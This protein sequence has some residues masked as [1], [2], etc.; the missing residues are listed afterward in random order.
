MSLALSASRI[1]CVRMTRDAPQ[2]RAEEV[3]G[4]RVKGH[5]QAREW[6]QEELASKM[7][8]AGFPWTQSIVTRTETATRPVRVD[9]AAALAALFGVGVDE[10]IGTGAKPLDQTYERL[11]R[12]RPPLIRRL[13]AA[14]RDREVTARELG[15]LDAKLAAV[16]RLARAMDQNEDDITTA[17]E[18]V[19][20]VFGKAE[21]QSIMIETG[22]AAEL[23]NM[24]WR[25]PKVA[26]T[27]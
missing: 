7:I 18:N 23:V 9:E 11:L 17:L 19:I 26:G 4:R 13:A 10:L 14:E 21:A 25:P 8:E 6:S 27:D 3:L 5:R 22:A 1:Y 24:G 16:S 12:L 2:V 20:E 15:D